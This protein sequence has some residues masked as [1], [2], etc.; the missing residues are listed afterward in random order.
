MANPQL[1]MVA[2]RRGF[3][4]I[5]MLFV[6]VIVA[7]LATLV[8]PNYR[9][10]QLKAQAADVMGR[11]SAINVAVKSYEADNQT[12]APFTGPVGEA[13]NFLTPY[14]AG[15]NYFAGPAD[16][17]FQLMRADVESPATLVIAANGEA[18][19]Q[20]LLAAAAQYGSPRAVV[21]GGGSSIIVQMAD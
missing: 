11:I 5:E 19:A 17:T 2:D 12:L 3:T 20:I 21:L 7:A 4:L 8:L 13:P 10:S 9:K 18:E 14:T 15:S 16:I 6:V 1:R